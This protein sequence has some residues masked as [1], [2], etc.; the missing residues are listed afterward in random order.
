MPRCRLVCCF[1]ALCWQGCAQAGDSAAHCGP[2]EPVECAVDVAGPLPVS[3]E[4]ATSTARAGA[5]G[6][7]RCGNGGG[8]AVDDAAFRFIAPHAGRYRISTEGSAFDTTL[9]IREGCTGREIVCNDDAA[10]R[11]LFSRVSIDLEACQAITIVVDGFDASQA[12][13]F[14]LHIDAVEASCTDGIDDDAD[15]AADCADADCAGPRCDLPGQWPA[16]WAELERGVLDAVNRV[17]AA[18]AVCGGETMPP[19]PPLERDELLELAARLHSQDM[20]DNDYLDH[21]SRDGRSVADR[22][23][24]TGFTGPG[25]IGE[26]IALG[27]ETVEAVM[28]G[29]MSSPGHCRNIMNAAYRTIGVGYAE[30]AGGRRWTQNFAGGH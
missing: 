13:A 22:I 16:A 25:P 2:P 6:G 27:Y 23:A 21:T 9:S 10:P 11:M 15:G 3:L 1:V 30:G 20:A 7:S 4:G 26:N 29:W 24:A 19:V 5:F 17:R 8:D 12:G 14:V 18:G 28:D